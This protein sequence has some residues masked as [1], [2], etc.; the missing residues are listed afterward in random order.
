MRKKRYDSGWDAVEDSA[1]EAANMKARIDLVIAI[2]E[3]VDSWK[4][5]QAE[6]AKRLGITQP[7]INDLIRGRIDKFSLDAL[8]NLAAQAGLTVRVEIVGSAA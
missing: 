4:V 6:A 1:V 8:V 3:A 2:H 7:R 5:T